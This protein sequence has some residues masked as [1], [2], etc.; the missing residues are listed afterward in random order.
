M[1]SVLQRVLRTL[2]AGLLAALPLILTVVV[3][4]WVGNFLIRMA[5]P[6]SVVGQVLAAIG[7]PAGGNR[8]LAYFFGLVVVL[9]FFY[10]FGSLVES[11]MKERWE[12]LTQRILRRV[13]VIGQIYEVTTKFV[14]LFERSEKAE[15]K[16]MSPVWVHFGGKGGTTALA[17]LPTSE[18]MQMGEKRCH[19]VLVP[20]APVPFGG[21]LFW[22]PADWV[23]QTDFGV[24]SLTSIYVSMGV[25]APEIMRSAAAARKQLDK[26]IIKPAPVAG[27]K[28][29]T[30]RQA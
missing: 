23:E 18:T 5:G 10:V 24:E 25:T 28:E 26:G 7:L 6:D 1:P 29:E 15:L 17:L 11:G 13:P 8:V 27:P 22:V 12:N 19:V 4:V 20:T 14:S 21:G 16:G 3:V 30:E 2:L 9:L